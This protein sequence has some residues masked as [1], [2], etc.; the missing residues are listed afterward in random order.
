MCHSRP[1]AFLSQ[2]RLDSQNQTSDWSTLLL[3]MH[4]L[5]SL[6]VWLL[7]ANIS[8]K[9]QMFRDHWGTTKLPTWVCHFSYTFLEVFT[10]LCQSTECFWQ[11]IPSDYLMN[12]VP[13]I[14]CMSGEASKLVHKILVYISNSFVFHEFVLKSAMCLLSSSAAHHHILH[15][16]YFSFVW[17]F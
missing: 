2:K 6:E 9:I 14:V 3:N 16:Y 12:P 7:Q 15:H 8:G 5:S 17:W 13:V 10:M 1:S 4:N 11:P